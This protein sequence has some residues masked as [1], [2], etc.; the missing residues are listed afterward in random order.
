MNKQAIWAIAKKDMRAIGANLQVWLPMIILPVVLGVVM[1]TGMILAFGLTGNSPKGIEQ[2][3]QLVDKIPASAL[4][5]T[6]NALPQISQ[7]ISYIMANYLLGAFYLLIPLMSASVISA[8]SFAGEKERGTLET[9]LFAPVDLLSLFAGKILASFLPA[10]A[11]SLVTFL[12]SVISVNAAGWPQFHRL[13]FPTLNWL[14]LLLLVMP[15]LSLLAI[16]I[17]I[18]ISAR[19]ATFQAAYQMGGMVVLPFILLLAGQAT[20]VLMLSPLV[21]LA[22]GAV[23]AIIDA[24]LLRLLVSRLDRNRLFESQVR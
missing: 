1:P 11:L 24:I 6:L 13:F 17:N 22:L 18:F 2:L 15:L 23:L 7:K 19:V 10:V 9:I 4:K 20:G 21:V 8:D 12:L 3:M 14:P 16:L 5:D